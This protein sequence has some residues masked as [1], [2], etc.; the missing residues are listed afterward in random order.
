MSET[1]ESILTAF[2]TPELIGAVAVTLAGTHVAKI[3]AEQWY[4]RATESAKR[5]RAFCAAV[6]LC[7]GALAGI[8]A[9][10][11]TDAPWYIAPA[12][13]FGSGPA[14]SLARRMVPEKFRG[15]LLTATDRQFKGL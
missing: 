7:I 14:W 1:I 10:I 11:G 3:L 15:V 8:G 12:V 4:P 5:W 9:W 13:A 6:S 2:L